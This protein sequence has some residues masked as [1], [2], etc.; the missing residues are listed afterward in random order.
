MERRELIK[1]AL[2]GAG[3][4]VTAG[5]GSSVQLT[6]IAPAPA[7]AAE[8][9]AKAFEPQVFDAHQNETVVAL[10]ELI[11]PTTDTPGA[12]AAKVNEYIDLYLHDVAEDKGHSFLMGLGW[13][14]GRA[15]KLYA[16]PFVGL[17][18][19]EQVAILESLDGA[20]EKELKPGAEFFK[21]LKRLTVDGYYTSKIGIA[22]LNKDGVPQTFACTH[23]SHA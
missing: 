16:K 10:S 12:K 22:E 9:A 6:S 20:E 2:L 1:S 18:E 7:A 23:D 8:A 3:A 17:S 14:D 13:L 4:A 21:Q 5:A 11:I 15:L 19:A